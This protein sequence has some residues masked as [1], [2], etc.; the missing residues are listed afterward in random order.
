[1]LP[2]TLPRFA[3]RAVGG[4]RVGA[5][6]IPGRVSITDAAL[7]RLARIAPHPWWA[8]ILIGLA[9]ATGSL[10]LR[11]AL[12]GFYGQISGFIILL[13]GVVLAGLAAGRLA[14]MT[15]VVASLLGGWIIAGPT[16]VGVGISTP[17]GVV[18]TT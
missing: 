13:P 9:F 4:V 1:M 15:A 8:S 5:D 7:S 18:A 17:M 2:N 10:A 16:A 6:G 14:G 3:Q 11:W 12:S